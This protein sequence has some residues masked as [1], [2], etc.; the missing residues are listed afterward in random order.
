M[1]VSSKSSV[2]FEDKLLRLA[3]AIGCLPLS[4]LVVMLYQADFSTYLKLL[5]AV[6]TMAFVVYYAFE[7][8]RLVVAQ[9]RTATN[10]MEALRYGDYSMRATAQGENSALTEFNSLLNSLAET[11]A[12][13]SL[14]GRERQILLDKV[15]TQID[16]AVV[17][18]D[19]DD[20]ISLMNPAAEKLFG[21]KFSQ[22][23]GAPIRTLGLQDAIVVDYR[24]VVEFEIKQHRKKVYLH[25]DDYFEQGKKHRLIFI[26]DIQDLLR[27][28]ERRAWQ[29]LLRVLSHE[30][31]NS[32]APIA[33]ISESLYQSGESDSG[34]LSASDFQ[35][36]LAV[37]SERSR[38]LN[39]FI[40]R[41]QQLTKLPTPQKAPVCV[42]QLLEQMMTLFDNVILTPIDQSLHCFADE[43]QLQQVLVNVIK[44]AVEACADQES[45]AP[46]LI[47]AVTQ[48][49]TLTISI[50]DNGRGIS[51]LD[52]L[53]IPFYTTKKSGS[54]IG[55]VMSR[56]IMRSHGG[57]FQ[58]RNRE[59]NDGVV[60]TLSIGLAGELSVTD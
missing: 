25:C 17:A 23:Q 42:K 46:I 18:V 19:H 57:D 34:Q 27:D 10:L 14:L 54:G 30:I 1:S 13:Q 40:K 6:I 58:L 28:E 52:N 49:N 7:I 32:L 51:N 3:L 39:E 5:I 43:G 41:Y 4:L 53:F 56:Q 37:I 16:V 31:N 22:H 60:A 45:P 21:A 9:L 35:Q 48:S 15:I 36:G 59:D 20:C 33:S 29:R 2:T 12:R 26:T 44:N 24:Q 47:T 38:H 11:M 50:V 8:K 55:L